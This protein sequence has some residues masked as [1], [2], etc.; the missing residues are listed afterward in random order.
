MVKKQ[1][2]KSSTENNGSLKKKQQQQ[3][4]NADVLSKYDKSQKSKE[5]MRNSA[6]ENYH[7]CLILI[8]YMTLKEEY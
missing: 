2:Y 1:N 7:V 5:R 8:T 3:T 6:T 4:Q